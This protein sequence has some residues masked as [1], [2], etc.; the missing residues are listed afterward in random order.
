MTSFRVRPLLFSL[1]IH[2]GVSL[3]LLAL[4]IT[5]AAAQAQDTTDPAAPETDPLTRIDHSAVYEWAAQGSNCNI[6]AN[7]LH[8]VGRAASNNG[9]LDGHQFDSA[10]TLEP[11]LFGQTGDGTQTN[12]AVLVDS[13]EGLIDGD[14]VWDRPVGP[15]QILPASWER[16]GFD[17][18]HDGLAD[19]QNLWDAA[20]SAANF[21]CEMGAGNGGFE[22]I[23]LRNYAGSNDLFTTMWD[24]YLEAAAESADS[25]TEVA[26]SATEVADSATEVADNATGVADSATPISEPVRG[27]PDELLMLTPEE[28]Q[29][30]DS[31]HVLRTNSAI[32][33][34]LTTGEALEADINAGRVVVDSDGELAVEPLS[35]EDRVVM[36]GDWDGDGDLDGGFFTGGVFII[37][38]GPAVSFANDGD[39]AYSGDW[40]GD[41]RD[42]PAVLRIDDEGGFFAPL[43]SD[44]YTFA[45]QVQ[46]ADA[47]E[48]TPL[49]GDW[50]GDGHDSLALRIHGEGDKDMI[51][52]YD[53]FGPADVAPVEVDA[54]SIVLAASHSHVD[55]LFPEEVETMETVSRNEAMSDL[56]NSAVSSQGI[57]AQIHDGTEIE[58]ADV[59]GI[60]V[61]VTIAENVEAMIAAAEIDGITLQGWGWRSHERQIELRIAHCEDP[62]ETPSNQCS[63]P[64]ATPGHSRHEFGLA[65]DFH[66]DSRAISTSTDQFAWLNENAHRFGLFNLPSEP[67]HWSVDGR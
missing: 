9:Q 65:I 49:I 10:A 21:L 7:I 23:A 64:T 39:I 34:P 67:W 54:D 33:K 58:L 52:F 45:S 32:D 5:A 61:A 47:T 42:T 8:A 57:T 56:V 15:F 59:R 25:A 30:F 18:N 2:I 1:K 20:A 51:E 36:R 50:D 12:L 19:P 3:T 16:Y 31:L 43:G 48:V 41:G 60:R 4:I 28:F 14:V 35:I 46:I 29:D 6:S 38:D 55:Q 62:W 40:D 53:R 17:A 63:P 37:A 44:G 66:V 24:Y 13:D 27:E 22:H 11:A 26:D